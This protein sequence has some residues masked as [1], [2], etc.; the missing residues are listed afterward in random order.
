MG[1]SDDAQ[2]EFEQA[3]RLDPRCSGAYLVADQAVIGLGLEQARY[4]NGAGLGGRDEKIALLARSTPMG[5][6]PQT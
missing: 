1:R 2:R 5:G 4:K 6:M 3:L